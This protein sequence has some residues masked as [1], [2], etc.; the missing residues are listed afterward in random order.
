[1]KQEK[2]GGYGSIR[3]SGLKSDNFYNKLPFF[4]SFRI[5]YPDC[6]HI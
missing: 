1:M 4:S 2:D 6:N 5:T 3:A